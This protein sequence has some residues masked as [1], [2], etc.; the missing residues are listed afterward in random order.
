M[1][2]RQE[3]YKS[4]AKVQVSEVK[5]YNPQPRNRCKMNAFINTFWAVSY[6]LTTLSTYFILMKLCVSSESLDKRLILRLLLWCLKRA[7]GCF[8][9]KFSWNR[10]YPNSWN[11]EP[12]IS[13]FW[14]N[15]HHW[16]HC[17][18][19]TKWRLFLQLTFLIVG[20][21]YTYSDKES[22]LPKC[23]TCI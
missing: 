16:W 3:R 12:E 5:Q 10:A 21:I 11:T 1:S 4:P 14:W 23:N 19:M 18:K 15:F 17:S 6:N 2:I 8:V 13:S 20:L 22:K 9:V 7:H